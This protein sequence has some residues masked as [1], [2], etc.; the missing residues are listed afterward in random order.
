LVL[1]NVKRNVFKNTMV[2]V[3]GVD[4]VEPDEFR[5]DS[6]AGHRMSLVIVG[7]PHY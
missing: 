2:V 4:A 3:G 6:G 1:V 5:P 7:T